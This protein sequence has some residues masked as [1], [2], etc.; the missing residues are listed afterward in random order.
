MIWTSIRSCSMHASHVRLS[1]VSYSTR[2]MS[3]SLTSVNEQ[4]VCRNLNSFIQS[5]QLAGSPSKKNKSTPPFQSEIGV[6]N[7]NMSISQSHRNQIASVLPNI[8]QSILRPEQH[9]IK[10]KKRHRSIGY[11]LET[12]KK[13][14]NLNNEEL[15]SPPAPCV[16]IKSC[17][18]CVGWLCRVVEWVLM[19]IVSGCWISE[20][21]AGIRLV[22]SRV[23]Y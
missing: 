23:P 7:K 19:R 13:S 16:K 2:N 17:K 10:T 6:E 9:P 20:W 14:I 8:L 12:N 4:V 22:G 18:K 5:R 15:V 21:Y 11:P 3:L 1:S